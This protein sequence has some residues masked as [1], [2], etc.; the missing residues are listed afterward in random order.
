MKVLRRSS[1]SR[2]EQQ[3][4]E[5]GVRLV[6]LYQ[7]DREI[8][9]NRAGYSDA[10]KALEAVSFAARDVA[11]EMRRYLLPNVPH[12]E[13]RTREFYRH[14]LFRLHPSFFHAQ[15]AETPHPISGN[16]VSNGSWGRS[17]YH[18]LHPGDRDVRPSGTGSFHI[19][20]VFVRVSRRC[21][22]ERESRLKSSMDRLEIAYRDAKCLAEA[23][24][25]FPLA[26]IRPWLCSILGGNKLP[27]RPIS[28]SAG[29]DEV[30]RLGVAFSSVALALEAE[31]FAIPSDDELR[32]ARRGTRG[33]GRIPRKAHW[34]E[35]GVWLRTEG[36]S[37]RR[38]ARHPIAGQFEIP[39]ERERGDESTL[40]ALENRIADRIRT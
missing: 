29:A 11:F 34:R 5:I 9:V 28:A 27:A 33:K 31:S 25:E 1:K 30:E 36:I 22:E 40:K 20:A 37:A 3:E 13:P 7:I 35:F 16:R 10:T 4:A 23:H 15:V 32:A 2:N 38:V 18:L 19:D 39:D 24:A 8:E 17:L 12:P 14:P 6:N 21:V 26:V